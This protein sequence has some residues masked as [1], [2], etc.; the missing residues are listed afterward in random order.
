MSWRDL[1][2]TE[3]ETV[4]APWV[5]GRSLRTFDRTW[6]IQGRRPREHGWWT[7]GVSGRNVTL[8]GRGEAD[9][10]MLKDRVSGYLIGDRLVR[11]HVVVSDPVTMLATFPRVHL[12]EQGLDRFERVVAG[13][14]CEDGPLVYVEQD[15]PLGAEY[16]VLQAYQD[17]AETVDRISEVAPA[18]DAAF[19]VETW[20]RAEVERRRQ[21]ER[22]RRERE[23]RRRRIQEQ[24]G[25]AVGRRELAAEDFGEAAKASLAVGGATYL[26]HRPARGGGDEMVVT[27]RLGEQRFQCTCSRTTMR[28]IDSGICLEDHGTGVRGDTRFTLESLPSVIREADRRGELVVLR[29]VS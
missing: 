27:F 21:E 26:D 28:V 8:Q 1:L 29:H 5:G 24:L 15:M 7:F 23:E 9:P 22:E 4:T 3:G 11:D 25:D 18:L 14:F 20:H 10:D 17:R 2:Q 6:R 12:V 13:R 16:E 19:R